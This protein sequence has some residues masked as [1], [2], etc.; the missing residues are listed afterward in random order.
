MEN[1]KQ[2]PDWAIR[3]D[4]NWHS[5]P[6][7]KHFSK[8]LFDKSYVRPVVNEAW[9]I[10]KGNRENSDASIKD[11]HEAQKVI[12][13]FQYDSAPMCLGR[14][15]QTICDARLLPLDELNRIFKTTDRLEVEKKARHS[16]ETY[17]PYEHAKDDDLR[18]KACL[19]VLDN[20]V[21]QAMKGLEHTFRLLGLN[22]WEGE[23]DVFIEDLNGIDLKYFLKPDYCNLIELKVRTPGIRK[24]SKKGWAKGSLP[25]TPYPGWLNQVSAY[26][27]VTKRQPAIIVAND[28]DYRIFHP[29]E[30]DSFTEPDRL[31]MTW[32]NIEQDLRIHERILKQAHR[33]SVEEGLNPEDSLKTLLRSV[34]P[35]WSH[36]SWSN[37]NPEVFDQAKSLWGY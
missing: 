31:H 14:T 22:Q 5:N 16:L 29:D 37:L 1:R 4:F 11:M 33:I 30:E 23:K 15:V 3:Y 6:A 10:I 17:V 20:T 27:H 2:I 28:T 7:S 26:H 8:T 12:D 36:I 24:N 32:E 35:D 19:E 13:K 21:E 25:S 9:E 18:A 34:V